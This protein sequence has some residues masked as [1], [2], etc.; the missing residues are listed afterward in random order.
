MEFFKDNSKVN[1]CNNLKSALL[2]LTNK[3]NKVIYQKYESLSKVSNHHKA[4]LLFHSNHNDENVEFKKNIRIFPFTNDILADIGYKAIG[5][6]LLP[7]NN[8]FPLLQFFLENPGYNFY[9]LI[10][11]DVHYNGNWQDFFAFFL[12][13]NSADFISSHM[14]DF[15]E[16]PN[17]Y[18]WNTLFHQKKIIL[19]ENKVRSFN[20]IYRLSNKALEYLHNQLKNGWQGHHEVLIPTLLKHGGFNIQDFGGLGPYVPENCKN[21]F[22]KRIDIN[23][24][25]ELF[26]NSMRFKPNIFDQEITESLLYHPAKFSEEKN[27]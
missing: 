17:W 18:W 20:P 9:W 21:R 11:D 1:E 4:Y 6:D 27:I 5:E 12:K 13:F 16:N 24:S 15:N 25:N 19:S 8:H 2:L 7:G 23:Q 3:T 10:E 14:N 22:Y 26:G